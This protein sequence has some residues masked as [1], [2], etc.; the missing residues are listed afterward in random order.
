[1]AVDEALP[2][3]AELDVVD[4]LLS[5]ASV[6]VDFAE[7]VTLATLDETEFLL[8][9]FLAPQPVTTATASAIGITAFNKFLT[10]IVFLSSHVYR[11]YNSYAFP[12]IIA[13]AY[14]LLFLCLIMLWLKYNNIVNNNQYHSCTNFIFI[15]A[16]FSAIFNNHLPTF[17]ILSNLS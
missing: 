5:L 17:T 1:V 8:V 16:S 13:L 4:V 9:S 11:N 12:L 10:L 7:L 14:L 2:V 3:E 6:E 15:L